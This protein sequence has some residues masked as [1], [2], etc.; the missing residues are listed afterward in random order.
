M[1]VSSKL[2]KKA[3]SEYQRSIQDKNGA[4][5][6]YRE[7][8]KF[9]YPNESVWESDGS[10]HDKTFGVYD[11]NAAKAAHKLSNRIITLLTPQGYHWA[12]LTIKHLENPKESEKKILKTWIKKVFQVLEDS[13]FYFDEGPAVKNLI[14][15]TAAMQMNYTGDPKRPVRFKS[16]PLKNLYF[17]EDAYSRVKNVFYKIERIR[18]QEILQLWPKAK[19]ENIGDREEIT[20]VEATI[21][22]PGPNGWDGK[23]HYI[24]T[25]DENFEHIL[26][27]EELDRFN[28]IVPRWEKFNNNSSWGCGQPL[29]VL[30]AIINLNDGKKGL[31]EAGRLQVKPPLLGWGK[32]E[33]IRNARFKPETVTYL[34]QSQGMANVAPLNTSIS[35]QAEMY[36]T[37]DDK[38]LI[39]EMFFSDYLGRVTETSVRTATEIEIRMREFYEVFE[40]VYSRLQEEFLKPIIM[41]IFN[42]LVDIGEID[43]T[44]LD[45]EGAEFEPVYKNKLTQNQE[46]QELQKFNMCV[47]NMVE[48]L[49]LQKTQ[50]RLDAMKV[51]DFLFDSYKVDL[52]RVAAGEKEA[53]K[54]I[55]EVE[56]QEQAAANPGAGGI[57]P[58][59]PAPIMGP[60]G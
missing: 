31:K 53:K 20:A 7:A 46:N 18:K 2:A 39:E 37:E 59:G 27:S 54:R 40:P 4:W 16:I 45:L 56:Q 24:V 25:R 3:S 14:V 42:I 50:A 52:K 47:Q 17:T 10:S 1:G 44:E 38:T 32:P 19:V 35:L 33:I 51:G 41:G 8:M 28:W 34:G 13:N 6:L 9:I 26:Y 55:A 60:G 57:M 12:D 23:F 58:E 11:S 48:I 36:N 29:K 5:N 49:G 21:F 22:E 15:G 43:L 30:S